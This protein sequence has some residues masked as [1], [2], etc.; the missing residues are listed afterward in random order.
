MHEEN[1][2]FEISIQNRNRSKFSPGYECFDIAE[3]V[4]SSDEIVEATNLLFTPHST[5]SFPSARLESE[6]INAYSLIGQ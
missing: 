2:E 3:Q 5:V 4:K 1:E 6:K